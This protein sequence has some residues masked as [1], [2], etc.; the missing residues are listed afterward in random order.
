MDD[1]LRDLY[2]IP[3]SILPQDVYMEDLALQCHHLEE[4]V[5][6]VL[7]GLPHRERAI[8]EAYIAARD[9]LAFQSVKQAL[10]FGLQSGRK[11]G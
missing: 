8:L 2:T 9:E 3:E 10:H 5:Q 4:Q 11:R 6:A 7:A 1:R